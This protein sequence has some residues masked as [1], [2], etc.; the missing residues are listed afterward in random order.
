[1][2]E[3]FAINTMGKLDSGKRVVIKIFIF[4]MWNLKYLYDI[5]LQKSCRY[6]ELLGVRAEGVNVKIIIYGK[7][8]VL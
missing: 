3:K 7:C 8:Y 5:Q 2:Q 4:T 1:M 6:I